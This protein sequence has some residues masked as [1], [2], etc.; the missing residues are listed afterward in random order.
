MVIFHSY[1]SLAEGKCSIW[2]RNWDVA[3]SACHLVPRLGRVAMSSEHHQH[4]TLKDC[5]VE[6]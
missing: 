3:K 6:V 2:F 5:L 4:V 1:V